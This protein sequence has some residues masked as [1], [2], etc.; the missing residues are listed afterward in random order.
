MQENTRELQDKARKICRFYARIYRMCQPR[1]MCC[2]YNFPGARDPMSHVQSLSEHAY[3]VSKLAVVV[4]AEFYDLFAE[5]D[6]PFPELSFFGSLHDDPEAITGDTTVVDKIPKAK[7]AVA[8]QD[9]FWQIY[10]ELVI[11]DFIQAEFNRYEMRLEY[12]AKIAKL[13]DAL[14]LVLYSQLCVRNGL[15]LFKQVYGSDPARF[16]LLAEGEERPVDPR[17]HA[18]LAK[19]F[20]E[21]GQVKLEG[22]VVAHELPYVLPGSRNMY[23]SSLA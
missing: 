22:A 15:N 12:A 20:N 6:I 18:E 5:A 10:G 8:E 2:R 9:A 16:C 23:D 3:L 13:A 1:G 11:Y 4:Y 14:E 21:Y 7:K 19:Y 17:T